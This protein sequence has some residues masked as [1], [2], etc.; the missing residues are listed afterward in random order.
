MHESR[1]GARAALLLAVAGLLLLIGV[2]AG[3]VG[4]AVLLVLAAALGAYAWWVSD[5]MALH[6]LQAYPV[7]E[8]QQPVMFRLVRELSTAARLPM[9]ALYVS[10][11][12]AP[13][14]FGA[15]RDRRHAAI[16]CTEGLLARLDER[17][18]RAVLG[19]EVAHVRHRD[20]VAAVAATLAGTV[21]SPAQLAWRPSA[22]P[23]DDGG[24][25]AR[26][27]LA[28]LSPIAAGLLRFGVRRSREY[29][30]DAA[31]AALTGDP[32]GLARALRTLDTAS[33]AFP[34]RP[35]P[36]LYAASALMIVGPFR[37]GVLTRL[38]DT[39]PPTAERVARLEALAGYRR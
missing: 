6:A 29:D 8:A 7:G 36:R 9:P 28:V 24:P 39:H 23:D 1:A 3:P 26:L 13:N 34:L 25:V 4:V 31:G 5:R 20:R 21:L 16:C 33:R 37:P 14:A 17:E 35:E 12:P 32:V 18:L 15:G 2:W 19:R 30:A 10:P 27:L 38:L 22:R 11:T